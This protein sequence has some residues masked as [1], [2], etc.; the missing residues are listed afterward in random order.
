MCAH[1]RYSAQVSCW[2]VDRTEAYIQLLIVRFFRLQVTV[3]ISIIADAK[4]WGL[5]MVYEHV[6]RLKPSINKISSGFLKGLTQRPAMSGAPINSMR[7][8]FSKVP[9]STTASLSYL[10]SKAAVASMTTHETALYYYTTALCEEYLC[11]SRSAVVCLPFEDCVTGQ[12]ETQPN[13]RWGLY[14]CCCFIFSSKI[15]KF[16][17]RPGATN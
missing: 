1:A 2:G 13:V 7:L 14:C 16:K 17:I 4:G 5:G 6:D 15:Q 3:V 9:H 11:G 12:L 8:L 10:A